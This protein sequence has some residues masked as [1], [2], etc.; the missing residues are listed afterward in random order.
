MT[1][2]TDEQQPSSIIKCEGVD[3]GVTPL[4]PESDMDR[5]DA[6]KAF[7]AV[8]N[9]VRPVHPFENHPY[10]LDEDDVDYKVTRRKPAIAGPCHRRADPTVSY[11]T[12]L[13]YINT[14]SRETHLALLAH[15]V[16]HI[17]IGSHSDKQAGSHPPRF[18]QAYGVNAAVVHD[19]LT[20]G[21]LGRV[22]PD[23]DLSGFLDMVELTVADDVVD[24]RYWS[25]EECRHEV[26]DI[27]TF[28]RFAYED[29]YW[30]LPEA[31]CYPAIEE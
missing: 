16:T 11:G 15:E 13:T 3:G 14:I 1:A 24:S 19:A 4:L 22:F 6:L 28:S 12:R 26:F 2:G 17:T 30:T 10:P 31:Y 7:L 27:V 29:P 9:T 21:D 23:T 5:D 20:N 18:W 8:L 25:V